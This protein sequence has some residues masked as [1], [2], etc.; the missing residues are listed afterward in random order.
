MGIRNQKLIWQGLNSK[1]CQ[2]LLEYLLL[3]NKAA[4]DYFDTRLKLAGCLYLLF[5]LGLILTDTG[6]ALAAAQKNEVLVI[7]KAT[8]RDLKRDSKQFVADKDNSREDGGKKEHFKN[9]FN[10]SKWGSKCF[11]EEASF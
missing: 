3:T 9:G 5:W 4:M 2:G 7:S 6:L 11:L 10:S 1:H 8:T